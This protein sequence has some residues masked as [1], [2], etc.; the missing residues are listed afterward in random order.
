MRCLQLQVTESQLNVA[1][2]MRAVSPAV[3]MEVGQVLDWLNEWLNNLTKDLIQKPSKRLALTFH[4]AN[5]GS[6]PKTRGGPHH[7]GSSK[8]V[9][10][11]TIALLS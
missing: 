11:C 4:E 1:H 8:R 3:R 2:T 10:M 7:P 5:H 6:V 9:N